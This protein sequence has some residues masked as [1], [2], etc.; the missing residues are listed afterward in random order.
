MLFRRKKRVE[1]TWQLIRSW[2]AQDGP[3]SHAYATIL[4]KLFL[5]PG[6]AEQK[7]FLVT[8]AKDGDG[9]TVTSLNL[10]AALAVRGRKVLLVDANF[11]S[12]QLGR[13]LGLHGRPGLTDLRPNSDFP[14]TA[15]PE[16]E[17]PT[18]QAIPRGTGREDLVDASSWA[19]LAALLKKAR[20]RYDLVL[21]DGPSIASGVEPL[22]L[23]QMVD[24]I[25]FV[26]AADRT[27]KSEAVVARNLIQKNGGRIAGVVLNQVPAYLPAFYTTP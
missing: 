22:T 9:K 24:G 18:L 10:A 13:H 20:T 15:T 23:G 27:Q 4:R 16:P 7:V 6:N 12:P 11:R 1:L 14:E 25:I 5:D 21:V 2:H 3:A 17:W 19:A 26:L 8:S